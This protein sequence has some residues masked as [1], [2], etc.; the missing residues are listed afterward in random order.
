MDLTEFDR[1]RKT[2][3]TASG[4]VGYAEMG[5][6]PDVALFVHGVATNAALW[7]NAIGDLASERRCVAIDLP[8]HG[9][10]PAR[11]GQDLSLGAMAGVLCEFLDA[12]WIEEVDLVANDTGG[13]VAQ[14]FAAKNP[15]RLRSLVLTNCDTRD[16][17]PPEAF[18][19]FVE[20]AGRG[21]LA[22]L[23]V[24]LAA[25]I[26]AARATAFGM[27][28][29][30][31]DLPPDDVVI[32]FLGPVSATLEKGREFERMLVSLEPSDLADADAGLRSLQVPT[33]LVWGTADAF[34]EPKWAQ[35][36]AETIPGVTGIVEIEGGKLFFPD[37]RAPEFVDA[38]REF[39]G[40]T[41]RAPDSL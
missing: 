24:E 40:S 6:G 11:P 5:D 12:L 18:K 38:V 9:R 17:I 41:R 31:L 7:R 1:H 28:Y 30:S 19:P 37:E 26:A 21:E 14:V 13:A 39:W 8:L 22:P 23:A 35:W 20:M 27:G 32:S 16:N 3:E 25:D 29:E 34:F 15:D 36:L 2:V 4:A 10:T 33:L